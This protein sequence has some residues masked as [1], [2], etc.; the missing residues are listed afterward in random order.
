MKNCKV[1]PRLDEIYAVEEPKLL[2]E[3]HGEVVRRCDTRRRLP[4]QCF[5]CMDNLKENCKE[6]SC[7]VC[8][9]RR[10]P[11]RTLLCDE[12]NGEFHLECLNPPLSNVP[13]D[14]DWYCP[15][16]KNDENEIVMVRAFY[17]MCLLGCSIKNYIF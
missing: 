1:Y 4:I 8:G 16:C 2:K 17:F 10:N 7:R 13:E 14:D 12:C 11:E 5:N 15:S 6:C 9:E 3:R